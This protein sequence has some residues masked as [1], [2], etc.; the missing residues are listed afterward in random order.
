LVRQLVGK[1]ADELDEKDADQ[2]QS[3]RER[4]EAI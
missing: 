3:R 4:R 1:H 2:N